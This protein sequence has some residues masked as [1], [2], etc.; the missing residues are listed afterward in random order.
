VLGLTQGERD[1]VYEAVVNLVEARLKKGAEFEVGGVFGSR[2][3]RNLRKTRKG[4]HPFEPFRELR[5]SSP[6]RSNS[7]ATP[8]R[9][10]LR[11]V[12]RKWSGR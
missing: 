9:R 2:M 1:A 10:R 3:A 12:L 7:T 4:A 5:V 11:A 6:P 8:C